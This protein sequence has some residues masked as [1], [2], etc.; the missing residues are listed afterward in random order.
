MIPSFGHVPV[1]DEDL[2]AYFV[3]LMCAFA[4][5]TWFGVRWAKQEKLDHEVIIDLSLASIITSMSSV[6]RGSP[7]RED[8]TEPPITYGMRSF[9]RVAAT[10]AA[11][12]NGSIGVTA[13]SSPTPDVRYPLRADEP[14]CAGATRRRTRPEIARA[15]RQERDPELSVSAR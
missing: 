9:S 7:T 11:M 15:G 14:P 4:A 10:R 6:E 12:S 3:M 8:A 2:P 13:L 1:L 5:C